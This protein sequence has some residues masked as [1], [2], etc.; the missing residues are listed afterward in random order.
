MWRQNAL[1]EAGPKESLTRLCS[2]IVHVTGDV[3][4]VGVD[5]RSGGKARRE[6]QQALYATRAIEL[7]ACKHNTSKHISKTNGYTRLKARVMSNR[8]LACVC[9]KLSIFRALALP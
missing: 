5:L 3:D 9:R 4:R 1:L 2:F 8:M 6:S 7:L